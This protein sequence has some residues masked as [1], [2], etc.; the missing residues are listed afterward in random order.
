MPNEVRIGL[1]LGAGA[2]RGWAHIGVLKEIERIGIE[3]E[4]VCGCSA[5]ALVGGSYV[6]G[7]LEDLEQWL[8]TLD[9]LAVARFYDV[10]LTSGGLIAGKRII[11]FFRERFGDFDIA[12]LPKGY[13]AVAT[14]LDTGEEVW[15]R[16]GSLLDAVRASIS[17]PGIFEPFYHEGKSYIDG[18]IVNPIPVSLCRALGAESVIAVDVSSDWT[19]GHSERGEPKS[20]EESQPGRTGGGEDDRTDDHPLASSI[21]HRFKDRIDGIFHRIWDRSNK[22]PGLFAVMNRSIHFM[23]ETITRSRLECDPAD[24]LLCP[25]T[26]HIGLMEFHRASEAIAAGKDCVQANEA[27]L[28]CLKAAC[29]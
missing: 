9:R 11:G 27:A 25:K 23:Q 22:R 5:G 20:F 21:S 7:H 16:S 6:S 1:A 26:G 17:M 14:D 4:I 2:A 29:R 19:A 8:L 13:G 28:N 18:G 10:S 3:P 12:S 15:F 24:L